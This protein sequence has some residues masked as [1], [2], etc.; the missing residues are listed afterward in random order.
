MI[1]RLLESLMIGMGASEEQLSD[2]MNSIEY[3]QH[4]NRLESML[5]EQITSLYNLYLSEEQETEHKVDWIKEG[6]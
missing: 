1:D 6:F 5:N 3:L 4:H 2:L